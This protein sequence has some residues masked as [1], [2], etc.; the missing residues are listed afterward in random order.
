ML[1]VPSNC[2]LLCFSVGMITAETTVPSTCFGGAVF[3]INVNKQVGPIYSRQFDLVMF[4]LDYFLSA[5]D[6][7]QHHEALLRDRVHQSFQAV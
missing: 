2:L 5:K 1:N 3:R 4:Q 7:Q 6:F